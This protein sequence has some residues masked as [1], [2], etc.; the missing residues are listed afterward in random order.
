MTWVMIQIPARKP[1][2]GKLA[3]LNMLI[4]KDALP[5]PR[6]YMGAHQLN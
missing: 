4:F 2:S 1:S 3:I 5:L 6:E